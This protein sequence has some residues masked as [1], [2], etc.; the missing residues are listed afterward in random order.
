VKSLPPG[1]PTDFKFYNQGKEQR[2]GHALGFEKSWLERIKGWIMCYYLMRE[3]DL[4]E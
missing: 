3:Y 1:A 2:S 4:C